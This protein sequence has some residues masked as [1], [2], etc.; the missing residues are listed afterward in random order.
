MYVWVNGQFVGY[1]QDSMTPASFDI[2]KY[3][4]AGKNSVSTQI[5]R[6]SDSSYI[7]DQDMWRFSG[8]F[9]SVNLLVRPKAHIEDYFFDSRVSNDLKSAK[10]RLELVLENTQS[11]LVSKKVAFEIYN[12]EKKIWQRLNTFDVD[13]KPN[14]KI[15]F[16]RNS[17][18]RGFKTWS[19]ETPNLYPYR[20][21]L[22]K[23][24][25]LEETIEGKHGFRRIEIKNGQLM[26]NGKTIMVNGVNRH[27][28]NAYTGRTVSVKNMVEDILLMKK[29]NINAVR[30]SHYPNSPEWYSL[31][32]E[33]G[34][35]LVDEANME[36]HGLRDFIPKSEKKWKKAT[37]D[38]MKNMVERD[39]NFSSIIIWSLGNEAGFGENHKNMAAWVRS[40]DNSRPVLYEQ[41][42]EDKLV[43]IVSPMYATIADVN[44]Y[45]NNKPYRPYIQVEYAHAMG[46]SLGNFDDYRKTYESHPMLQGGFI[47]DWVDQGL[48]KKTKDGTRYWAYGGDFGDKPND[49]NFCFNG[50]VG[51]DRSANPTL[52]EVKKVYQPVE[53]KLKGKN[54]FVENKY[55]FRKLDQSYN[56]TYDLY[57]EGKIKSH[58]RLK[59]PVVPPGQTKVVNLSKIMPNH[60]DSLYHLVVESA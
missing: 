26:V 45:K 14:S 28:H 5:Y 59:L 29:N 51:P 46:N 37:L 34:L 12:P 15:R 36:S 27:E 24:N 17:S 11:S 44:K 41:A 42:F 21:K 16:V 3:I 1:S 48:A 38:R 23:G 13:L 50:I 6:W 55:S 8:I 31:C 25:K 39:K 18:F 56:L 40:R 57:K 52:F 32:N 43:D 49:G 54:L 58:G 47:W 7:E 35:Y 4:K 9:R 2:S 53:F 33:Y 60:A 10:I 19:A 22:F 20:I 30:T